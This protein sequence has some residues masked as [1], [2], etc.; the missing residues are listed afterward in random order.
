MARIPD[1]EIARL[2]A[3]QPY[4]S[5]AKFSHKLKHLQ[6]RIAEKQEIANIN[7]LNEKVKELAKHVAA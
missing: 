1:A 2:K 3:Q 6:S 4:I 5:K 7:W